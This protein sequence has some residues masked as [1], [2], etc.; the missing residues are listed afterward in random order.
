MRRLKLAITAVTAVALFG[1]GVAWADLLVKD[2]L[3]V[4]WVIKNFVCES[5]K[6]CNATVLIDNTGAEISPLTNAQLRATPVPTTATAWPLPTGAATQ[7]TLA[8]IQTSLGTPF[9]AGASIGNTTFGA[10]QA[11]ASNLNATVVPSS[12]AAWGLVSAAQNGT[13]PTNGQLAMGQF[14]TTP[15]TITSGN[16]SPLQMD[17]SGNLRVNIAAGA[18]SGAVSQGSATSG[19]TGSLI[20]GAVTTA[21]PTYTT[22]QTSPLSLDTTGAL[23]VNVTAGGAGGGAVTNAGTFA[24]QLTG[25]TNNI[26]NISGTVS[27]PTGASTSANQTTLIGHVDGIETLI[28]ST[29]TKLDTLNSNVSASI[30]AGTAL[31]GDVNVR[32]GGTALSASNLMPT[33][34]GAAAAGGATPHFV[35]AAATNN[36]TS[37]KGSAGTVYAIQTGSI[38]ASAPYYLKLYDKATAPTCGTDTPVSVFV[39]PPANSGNNVS[40]VVGKAFTLG[41]GYCVVTGIANND[42]TAVPAAN[43]LINIDYK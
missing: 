8:A 36:S 14:N 28:G 23:R 7:A 42:N 10:T 12:L 17:A 21:A 41:I 33:Y 6:L 24:T 34:Q 29:N 16:V 25:S 4:P 31:I 3:G 40:V 35:V 30:P 20:Q 32:Q 37:L 26:A 19:Q 5:V 9:Q 13:T 22:A 18:S 15:T 43:L 1:G 27:L 38:A 11:T 39:I 2:G